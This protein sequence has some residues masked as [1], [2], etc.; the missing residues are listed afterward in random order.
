MF[1]KKLR[2]TFINYNDEVCVRVFHLETG[3]YD[4]EAQCINKGIDMG[5]LIKVEVV[6]EAETHNIIDD[7]IE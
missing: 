6:M 1:R 3:W 5:R 2:V 4:F 7:T